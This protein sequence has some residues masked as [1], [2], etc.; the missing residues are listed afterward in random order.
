[1]IKN[2]FKIAWRTMTRQKSY[3]AIN[4]LGLGFGICACMVI[5]LI[6]QYEF[7]F[8]KFHPDGDRIY[9]IVG[10]SLNRSG[11]KQF[12]NSPISD[13]AGFQN[14]IPG[15]EARSGFYTSDRDVT[16]SVPQQNGSPKKFDNL[17]PNSYSATTIIMW[18]DYFSIFKY[19]WL[20]GNPETLNEPFKVVLTE[21]RARKYFGNIPVNK[22]IG[23][24]VI[25]E[26]SLLVTVSGIVK[27]WNENTDFGYTDFVSISTATHSF[28]K[29]DI[30]TEDWSS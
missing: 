3:T 10:E 14:Q 2:Y 4:V 9:R 20:A 28:L 17:I 13:V 16:I 15:F 11:E 26:D 29:K 1:M 8:D 27:D 21:S 19:H 30:P 22:M 12:W 5:F 23:Q 18:P 6:T 24:T 25:Y 7:S